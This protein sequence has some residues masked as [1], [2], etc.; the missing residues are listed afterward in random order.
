MHD[1]DR[2]QL[3]YGSEISEFGEMPELA[4]EQF[5]S[6]GEL[7]NIL[8][9]L[10]GEAQSEGAF[11]GEYQ[12][13]QELPEI[14]H[15]ELAS[16]LLEVSNEQEL[17][18]FLGN[19]FNKVAGTIGK[20]IKSPVG[21]ALGGI[22]KTVAKKALPIAGGAL[23]TFVGGPLGGMVGSKLASMAGNAF[24][25][26]WEGLSPEDR[27]FEVAR[28]YVRFATHAA[29]KAAAAPPHIDPVKVAKAAVV[30]A[31]KKYAPGLLA[32]L[33]D[34]AAVAP[35]PS[36]YRAPVYATTAAPMRPAPRPSYPPPTYGTAGYAVPTEPTCPTCGTT[37]G[38]GYRRHHQGKWIRRGRHIVLLGV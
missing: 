21:Q 35:H 20:V 33:R 29:R 8:G 5:E 37:T 27:D 30:E 18:H 14:M 16:E 15:D 1:I 10:F 4:S 17:D 11:A 2:T 23:G 6:S 36:A 9:S 22:L 31:A 25:L 12:E 32:P 34:V 3:E 26:E 13:S 24:G 38:T 19:L 28:R 7:G